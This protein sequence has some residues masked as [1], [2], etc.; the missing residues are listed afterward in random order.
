MPDRR[1]SIAEVEEL[2]ELYSALAELYKR[3]ADDARRQAAEGLAF[4][5]LGLAHE[6]AAHYNRRI[7]EILGTG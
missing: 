7:R 1:L 3:A 4:G 6:A 2:E 5:L